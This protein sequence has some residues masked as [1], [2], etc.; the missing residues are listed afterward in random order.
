MWAFVEQ[1]REDRNR[2]GWSRCWDHLQ[3]ICA[4]YKKKGDDDDSEPYS[5][6]ATMD[7][8]LSSWTFRAMMPC[9]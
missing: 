2:M 4:A 1:S 9:H 5:D 8:V 3:R 6:N 7:G